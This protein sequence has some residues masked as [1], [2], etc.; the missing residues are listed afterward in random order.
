MAGELPHTAWDPL[1]RFLWDGRRHMNDQVQQLQ[2]ELDIHDQ[3][4]VAY[5]MLR[6]HGLP[7]P[8]PLRSNLKPLA[9]QGLRRWA[10]N[11]RHGHAR[12]PAAQWLFRAVRGAPM[13]YVERKMQKLLLRRP[14]RVPAV[15]GGGGEEGDAAQ[16]PIFEVQYR[17]EG[18]QIISEIQPINRAAEDQVQQAT[19]A[20]ARD[21]PVTPD[22]AAE[23]EDDEEH[24][25]YDYTAKDTCDHKC[26][27]PLPPVFSMYAQ[28][29]QTTD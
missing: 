9:S 1:W 28:S 18:A 20:S 11:I 23:G 6:F 16:A 10:K 4:L 15:R 24:T 12:T 22:A 21:A 13:P 14:P 26:L 3:A 19:T 7:C 25:T 29:I 27:P 17:K 5:A 2:E 8:A